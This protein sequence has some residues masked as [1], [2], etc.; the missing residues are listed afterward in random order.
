MLLHNP[1]SVDK[2]WCYP[3]FEMLHTDC[4]F[5]ILLYGADMLLCLYTET[6]WQLPSLVLYHVIVSLY[7]G[8][9][10]LSI[11]SIYRHCTTL[12]TLCIYVCVMNYGWCSVVSI[13]P[14]LGMSA[15]SKTQTNTQNVV[16]MSSMQLCSMIHVQFIQCRRLNVLESFVWEQDHVREMIPACSKGPTGVFLWMLRCSTCCARLATASVQSVSGLL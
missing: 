12:C 2:A 8:F 13:V 16:L 7:W 11:L 10:Q 4:I 6:L 15:L 3:S 9:I 14:Q 1:L 5:S